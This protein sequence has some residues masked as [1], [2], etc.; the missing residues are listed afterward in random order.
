MSRRKPVPA[1]IAAQAAQL[2]ELLAAVDPAA[3]E[4]LAGGAARHF[5]RERRERHRAPVKLDAALGAPPSE[6]T[7]AG[8][9]R[10]YLHPEPTRSP[11]LNAFLNELGGKGL[12]PA[13]ANIFNEHKLAPRLIELARQRLVSMLIASG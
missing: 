9:A 13:N 5:E 7:A 11:V 1:S 10:L 6:R 3:A 2:A 8:G 4:R 12:V